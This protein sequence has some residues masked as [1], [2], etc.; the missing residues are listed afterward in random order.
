M[1]PRIKKVQKSLPPLSL[2]H[3][4]EMN[5]SLLIAII[6]IVAI[7]TLSLLLLFSDQLVGKAFF[8]GQANSAGTELVS[9]TVP[10]VY[11]NQPFSLKV[12]AN[13]GQETKLVSFDLQLPSG[14]TCAEVLGIQNLLSGWSEYDRRC[15][16]GKI[17]FT[18]GNV[19]AGKSGTFEVAQIDLA[20]FPASTFSADFISFVAFDAN[21]QNQI[22]SVADPSFQILAPAVCGNSLTE[23]GEQ[24]D[25]GNADNNDACTNT[26]Q[27]N[28]CGDGFKYE[29]VEECDD[30]N[31]DNSDACATTCLKNN[32]CGDGA[33]GV[34]E[35]CDDNNVA[36][37]DGCSSTCQTEFSSC[38]VS[39]DC[40]SG[41][42]CDNNICRAIIC[43]PNAK[44]C[45]DSDSWRVCNQLGTRYSP[46]YNC[47]SGM[48]C[49]EGIC[50]STTAV[51]GNSVVESGELCDDGN[52]INSDGCSSTCQA[53]A[54]SS[55][56]SESTSKTETEAVPK[57]AGSEETVT[58]SETTETISEPPPENNAPREEVLPPPSCIPKT[59]VSD[60][61]EC[62]ALADDCGGYLDCGFCSEGKLCAVGGKCVTPLSQL[63]PVAAAH[64]QT[65]LEKMLAALGKDGDKYSKLP[66]VIN[67]LVAWWNDPLNS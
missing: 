61:F 58:E 62:G 51:C 19:I 52:N 31:L 66:A 23:S 37:G 3:Y 2:S 49:Q 65:L 29:G 17:I 41:Q 30:G 9:P 25:D 60:R 7:V 5:K 45:Y 59:C 44:S 27:S 21:D 18:Y 40:A 1:R 67:A 24:C 38:T 14:V 43:E 54:S 13:T 28:V 6:A 4:G 8:A 55:E 16:D 50:I 64:D 12:K 10:Q 36:S 46:I 39:A 34:D 15:E 32:V 11:E 47:A 33:I 35:Q 63:L 57:S 20:G 22:V 26:C 48:V 56:S 42:A 53:E